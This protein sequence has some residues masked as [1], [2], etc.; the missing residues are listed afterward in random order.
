MKRS[1]LGVTIVSLGVALGAAG[2]SDFLTGNDFVNNPNNPSNA[3]LQQT[4]MAV[5]AGVFGW[6]ESTLP[7]TTCMWMQQCTGIGGR[8]VEQYAQYTV[9]DASWSFD[10]SS[11][12]TGGGLIDIRR[13][14]SGARAANDRTWLGIGQVYEAFLIGSAASL[15][16]DIPYREAAS[17]VTKP[18]LDPQL[19]VYG[20]VQ[21]LLDSAI[22]NLNAATGVGPQASDLVYGGDRAK[23]IQAANTLK[24]RFFMHTA[25]LNGAAAYTAAITAAGSGISD[26]ANDFRTFHG[27]G[28]GEGNI[29]NQFFSTTFGSDVVAGKRLTDIM[30]ARS[31]PR[32]PQYFGLN[33]YGGYGGQDIN[34]PVNDSAVSRLG[35]TR[36]DPLFRQ[37]LVTYA[38][39]QLILA[40]AKHATGDDPGA[41]INLNNARA[42]VPLGALV[43]ITGA[44][45]LDSIMTEKYVALFQNIESYSDYRRTCRPA[46]TPY[47]TT[48]FANK[49]PGRLFYGLAEENANPN[50]PSSSVQLS[51][52]GFRN[53]NDPA[54]CP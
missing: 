35:G 1:N 40:E 3:T 26:K 48:E 41:L 13:V 20:D 37:P 10:F 52:N 44:A 47:P 11:V 50:I 24:A 49:V 14:Q 54:A 8:F 5:Q 51:T 4:F 29:W 30:V 43:G 36:N 17:N 18:V 38:E 28:T 32:L 27:S 46:L 31:D 53:P 42:I 22:V 7:L 19:Q 9:T 12:Y 2:C 15:W 23:W 45:L 6:Q 16:G 21:A 34:T 25:E 39:N 33:A